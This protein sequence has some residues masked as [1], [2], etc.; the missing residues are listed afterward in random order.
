MKKSLSLPLHSEYF[1]ILRLRGLH[2]SSRGQPN[3]T[4]FL[5]I[6]NNLYILFG[7]IK[8]E[9]SWKLYFLKTNDEHQRSRDF[10]PLLKE[11]ISDTLYYV[12]KHKTSTILFVIETFFTVWD[13]C[14]INLTG[15]SWRNNC[16]WRSHRQ[17]T[18]RLVKFSDK[19]GSANR[20][21]E[22]SCNTYRSSLSRHVQQS[23]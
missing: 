13:I 15:K 1:L 14:T 9:N 7:Y 11:W 6:I 21:C 5:L 4:K 16:V 2:N 19:L 20:Q 18:K 23:L 12:F 10:F 22:Q 3:I 8:W 17:T